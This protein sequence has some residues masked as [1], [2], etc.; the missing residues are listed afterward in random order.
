MNKQQLVDWLGEHNIGFP[1]RA[2][3]VQL[4]RLREDEI[5]RLMA[6]NRDR[7]PARSEHSD[8]S[9]HSEHSAEGAH[10]LNVDP[11][12]NA[13]AGR[14][15]EGNGIPNQVQIAAA[16]DQEEAVADAEL[17]ILEKRARIAQLRAELATVL[18]DER[19]VRQ[20]TY[21]DIKYSVLPFSGGEEYDANKWLADFD[22]V[23]DSVDGDDAFRLKCMRRLMKPDSEAE[24][25]LR[26]DSSTTYVDFRANFL[27]NFGH[28]YSVSD[29][30]EKMKKTVYIPSKTSVMG[31]ILQMQELASRAGIDDVQTIRYIID[32]LRDSSAHI[33]ILY[34]ATTIPVLKALAPR[35]VQLREANVKVA[36][37]SVRT[38]SDVKAKQSSGRT[39]SAAQPAV[40]SAVRCY[41]CSGVG[42][43]ASS[44]PEPKRAIGSCFRCGST[45]HI[46]KDCPK[47]APANP[48]RIA[49]VDDFRGAGGSTP[50]DDVDEA[51][52][53]LS[54]MNVVSVTFPSDCSVPQ[55]NLLES[56]FDTG[57]PI[58]LL[59]RS[60]VPH[61]L[62]DESTKY[63][64][65]RGLG[66]FRL[67]TY[68]KLPI[69]IKFCNQIQPITVYVVPDNLIPC[70][71]LLGRDF[72]RAFK[73]K[74]AI[75]NSIPNTIPKPKIKLSE[76]SDVNKIYVSDQALHCVYGSI[77]GQSS[78]AYVCEHCKSGAVSCEP[79][80]GE[81]PSSVLTSVGHSVPDIF[82]IEAISE[83]SRAPFVHDTNS[84]S[85]A[86]PSTHI[87]ATDRH[88]F[89]IDS[90]PLSDG[91]YNINPKL[92]PFHR[93]SILKIIDSDYRDLANI[94][95]I[96][97]DFEMKIRLSSDQPINSS[98]R[99]LSYA[100]KLVVDA[101][102]SD[103]LSKGIIRPS[104][105]PYS[106]QMISEC[107]WTIGR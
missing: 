106:F 32:G 21:K 10:G 80:N 5:E 14:A 39:D 101:K 46:L 61:K 75:C 107:A 88:I 69:K 42:H 33:A 104:N 8:H 4:R 105:S 48:S 6:D 53:Q 44:C 36:S 51:T 84:K 81:F 57:S 7:S 64:G 16:L 74:L 89:S 30:L 9:E 20:P 96:P 99:R 25:F 45:Q 35:Y 65:Y 54:E 41:N 11:D 62:T 63:S 85:N 2:T 43:M 19:G 38:S 29:I 90:D 95:E 94:P 91:C 1:R 31:Y 3:V 83:S 68:G 27:A 13:G 56:L 58:S 12:P 26:T 23:C 18:P 67:C 34:S 93:E 52:R 59:R 17:R 103:L 66:S 49:L 55:C 78:I 86:F 73:I 50:A 79:D 77:G 97:H 47:P 72:L 92:N 98:P 40:K 37:S 82:F 102:V 100:D 60:A 76:D 28:V 24:L 70:P 71:L 15:A 87:Y 22:R